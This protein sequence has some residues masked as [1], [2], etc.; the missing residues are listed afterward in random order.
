[1]VYSSNQ[2]YVRIKGNR[3]RV[4]K[5]KKLAAEHTADELAEQFNVTSSCMRRM[6]RARNIKWKEPPKVKRVRKCNIEKLLEVASSGVYT[7]SQLASLFGLSRGYV[8]DLCWRYGVEIKKHTAIKKS[9]KPRRYNEHGD[10]IWNV[11]QEQEPERVPEPTI[12]LPGT[13]EKAKRASM[14]S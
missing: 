1:M 2:D 14:A 8:S 12:A 10:A 7:A 9:A 4:A 6:M 3:V 11:P 13:S 5:L